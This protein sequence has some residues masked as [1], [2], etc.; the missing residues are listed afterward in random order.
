M[1]PPLAVRAFIGPFGLR[2]GWRVLLFFLLTGAIAAPVYFLTH[3]AP[4]RGWG[5]EFPTFCVSV[6][7]ATWMVARIEGRPFSSYGLGAIHRARNLASGI[8]S[9][10]LA[11]SL[12]MALLVAL[13]AFRPSG[14][15]LHGAEIGKWAIYW[16]VSFLFTSLSEELLTRGCPLFTLSQSIGFWP[17][18]VLL[19]LFF[20]A[21]HIGNRGEESV[22]IGNAVLAGLVFAYSVRW[23][24]TLWWAIG[25]HL[26]WDWAETF[27]YGVPNSGGAVTPHHFLSG[28]PAGP[29]WLSG[30]TVGPEGSVLATLALV[31]LAAAVRFTT[32][33]HAAA[34][35][36][37]HR[38]GEGV[39]RG[40]GCPPHDVAMNAS[41]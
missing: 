26:S 31:L 40:P 22:G 6:L 35:L 14:P 21:G 33:R 16:T 34:G 41:S 29:A 15:D 24:G 36:E 1:P 9:G 19:S 3:L 18:A 27:F 13:G 38:S 10:F 37:R 17:A 2:S 32:P 39:G 8:A 20:G 7:A 25:C 28:T 4:L 23:T 5:I 11:L 12:L 30:G